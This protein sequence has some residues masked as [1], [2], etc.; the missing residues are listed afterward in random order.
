[1]KIYVAKEKDFSG[2]DSKCKHMQHLIQINQLETT[3]FS[4]E[5][6]YNVNI[7]NYQEKVESALKKLRSSNLYLGHSTT[8]KV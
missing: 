1:M 2:T 4:K 7:D 6:K 3:V 8:I 5:I